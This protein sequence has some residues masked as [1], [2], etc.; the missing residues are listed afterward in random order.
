MKK[1]LTYLAIGLG[2]AAFSG[3][4]M[5]AAPQCS[6]II[7]SINAGMCTG[8]CV[9]QEQSLHPECF[10]SASSTATASQAIYSTAVQQM[11]AISKAVGARTAASQNRPTSKVANSGQQFGMAAGNSAAQWNVWGSINNDKNKYDR[12]G[13]ISTA[14]VA[15]GTPRNNTSNTDITNAVF[16][17]DYQLN[18]TVALGLSAAFDSGRGTSEAFA[19]GVSQGVATLGSNGY[20]VAPYVGWQINQDWSM[21][22]S[23]GFGRGKIDSSGTTGKAN[24]LF[25]GA[26]LSYA[27]WY[28]NWQ[29]TGKGS[30]LHGEEKYGD[31]TDAAV[32]LL[33]GTAVTNKIDQ[34]ILG[35]QAGYMVNDSVM[36]YVGL[37]LSND[38]SRS[39]S[40]SAVAQ[41][42]NE[43]GKTALVWALGVNFFS[44]SNSITGGVAYHHET[45]RTY[46]KNN[47]L[48]GN[49]NFRF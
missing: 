44:L 25:Y 10:G 22:A 3:G 31:L 42:G 17:G 23:L 32:G 26:N 5:A 12:G 7:S 19:A 30:F 36:P 4:A 11:L 20:T 16:G 6:A 35:A 15:A 41:Q 29:V 48:M 28:D 2:L 18:P 49:I 40:V 13:Y 21:D 24:R 43:L 34:L 45:G 46:A 27:N 33:P 14:V 9:A 8:A 39:T 1:F 47:S 37:N 38:I